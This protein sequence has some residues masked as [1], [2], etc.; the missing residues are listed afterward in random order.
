M[1]N[2]KYIT[3]LLFTM[4]LLTLA[5]STFPTIGTRLEGSG[6]VITEERQ[7]SNFDRVLLSGYGEVTIYQ[8]EIESLTVRTDDN[9]MPY[10]ETEVR[11]RTLEL[12]FTPSGS[13][14]SINPS[15]SIHF[16]LVVKDIS[17]LDISG[18]G[19]V[20][21]DELTVE[22]L[23]LNLSGAGSLEINNLVADELVSNISGAGSVLVAG[24]VTGQELNHSGVG[25]YYAGDLE[26]ETAL[27]TI[28]GAGSA[29]LWVR[30]TLDVKV[31]GVGN[32]IYYGTPRVIQNVSGLGKVISQGE[33]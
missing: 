16:D 18:A 26:S 24:Q 5:C 11:N 23:Q 9:I 8:G 31:S 27:V 21:A 13:R 33:K 30:E 7:V 20:T 12:G 25:S 32:I 4:V 1:K 15:D 29:T 14:R 22:K 3:G 6:N 28:S 10:I 19:S 2:K 17:R